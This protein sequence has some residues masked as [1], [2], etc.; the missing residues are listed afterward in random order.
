[1]RELEEILLATLTG[2]PVE[3]FETEAKKWI[4]GD[5]QQAGHDC[6]PKR[7]S[8]PAGSASTPI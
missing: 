6:C 1:L 3:V 5:L 4:D 7:L 2:M 8:I